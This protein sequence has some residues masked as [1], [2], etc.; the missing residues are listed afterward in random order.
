VLHGYELYLVEQ[1]ACSRQSPTLVIATYTGDKRHSIVVGVLSVPS[2]E[3]TWSPRLRVFFKAIQQYHARPKETK[4]GELMVTN[5]SS[6]PSA[7]TVIPVPGG[8]IKKH[9]QTF[10]VNEDLKRLQCSG[11]SGLTLSEPAPSTQA[12]FYQLYKASDRI[13][14]PQAVLELVKL[15]Q[16]ALF[17]F[18]YLDQE[19]MDG[20]LCD[21]TETAIRNWWTEVGAEYYHMEPSD[22]I[23]GPTTVAALLGTL[24]GARNR[25]HHYGAPVS[26]DVLDIEGTRR[27]ISYFQ[28]YQKLDR[29]RQ[30]DRQTLLRLQ[31]VTA[32]A[33]AGEGWG[34]PKA[35]KSTVA[36][37]GGKRG[38]IVM[39]MVSGKDRGGIG[40][41]E[42]LD[43]DKFIALASGERAKWLWHGKPRRT[44]DYQGH[45]DLANTFNREET[46]STTSKW[47]QAQ[48]L[49]DELESRQKDGS[50]GVYSQPP[51]GSA[52]SVADS[53]G[54]RDALHRTVFRTVAGRVSDA[55]SG[56]GRIKGAVGGTRRGH[57]S[58]PSKDE[59]GSDSTLLSPMMVTSPPLISATGSHVPRAFTWKNKPEEY[60]QH[61][62]KEKDA[63]SAGASQLTTESLEKVSTSTDRRNG[64]SAF[65]SIAS[66]VRRDIVDAAPSI[67]GS[68]VDDS[69]LLGPLLMAERN[70]EAPVHYLHRRHSIDLSRLSLKMPRNESRWPRRLSFGDAEEAILTWDEV[71]DPLEPALLETDDPLARQ[72]QQHLEELARTLN[73]QIT[74]IKQNL[75]P[76]AIAKISA[77]EALDDRHGRDAE[78]IA[79]LAS[80][81][82]EAYQ[83]VRIAATELV[84]EEKESLTEGIKEVEALQARLEYEIGA[85]A[86]RV[87]D[88]EEGARVFEA[89]VKELE[90]RAEEL[91]VQLETE[92]WV[93]WFVR[94]LTGIGTGP[95]ITR[96]R[97]K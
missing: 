7:F 78:D 89:N 30:L 9:Q 51:P 15:C 12:K 42:T 76:W 67:A 64:E 33:A 3:S 6:F 50:P 93:H 62:R 28:K 26:K 36:E 21:V 55:R 53:P 39:G 11:R 54:E 66:K 73:S 79:T 97:K 90:R 13:A 34:V 58:R 17:L 82:T 86:G 8:D 87:G 91:R 27:G 14:F 63:E 61:Y 40:E 5:L 31:A 44:T 65:N 92:S 83:R 75:E 18:G 80:Q 68:T 37:F 59:F 1:W 70:L 57:V 29:T 16:V 77:I 71:T 56:L 23:L 52:V 85:L 41:I 47:T 60:L 32:K 49:E 2:D 69:D 35:V 4:F 38:E 19:Y 84:A 43:I 74:S 94:T 20:L 81:L 96:P 45:H 48:P 22:G 72:R 10:M 24:M 88:V 25:L 46:S 95:N